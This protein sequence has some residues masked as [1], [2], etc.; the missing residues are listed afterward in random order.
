M[1]EY[2][3]DEPEKTAQLLAEL[4]QSLRA[5]MKDAPA[6]VKLNLYKDGLDK[7]PKDPTRVM[8]EVAP[9]VQVLSAITR[10]EDGQSCN[11]STLDIYLDTVESA[12]GSDLN[13]F[14]NEKPTH[15]TKLHAFLLHY[16]KKL[17]RFGLNLKPFRR[18]QYAEEFMDVLVNRGVYGGN[19]EKLLSKAREFNVMT[20]KLPSKYPNLDWV[21]KLLKKKS[22][23]RKSIRLLNEYQNIRAAARNRSLNLY[24]FARWLIPDEAAK[25]STTTKFQK[26]NEFYRIYSPLKNPYA[27]KGIYI[28]KKETRAKLKANIY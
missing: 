27:E 13:A 5:S 18:N 17:A 28:R 25:I 7:Y 19:D 3:S 11:R 8:R 12:F 20:A 6:D 4:E 14:V 16:G 22:R 23:A 2:G 10:M 24:N 21:S 26:L 15:D 9:I 1:Q